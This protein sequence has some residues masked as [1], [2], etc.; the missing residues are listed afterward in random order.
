MRFSPRA[1]NTLFL[2]LLP[3]AVAVFDLGVGAVLVLLALGLLWRWG[4][5]LGTLTRPGRGPDLRLETIGASHFVEKVRWCLDRLGIPYV[6][7]QNVG[8]LGVFTLGMMARVT[9][10][11][12]GRE[13]RS[14]RLTNLAF[15][16]INLAALVRVLFPLA[17]PA[18]YTTWLY[19]SGL[20]WTA[21]FALFLWTYAPMLIAPRADG[22]PG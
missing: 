13:M 20:L 21:A 11:H 6:E 2:L 17:L 16:T 14:A 1:Q 19:I 8:A 15:V 10:G 9:L 7:T 4:I 5:V 3:V 18:A 12:T 22:R